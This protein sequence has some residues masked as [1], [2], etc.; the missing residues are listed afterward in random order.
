V[1]GKGFL[2]G[3]FSYYRAKAGLVCEKIHELTYAIIK[4]QAEE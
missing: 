2:G 3:F 4:R 1:S